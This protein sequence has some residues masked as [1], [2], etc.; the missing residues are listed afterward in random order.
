MNNSKVLRNITS[1]SK[2]LQFDCN[3]FNVTEFH[4]LKLQD[5]AIYKPYQFWIGGVI[6][7]FV[8]GFGLLMN[9]IGICVIST[10]LSKQNIFNHMIVILFIVDSTFLLLQFLF[11]L[12]EYWLDESIEILTI[13]TPKFIIPLENIT[14]TL[15]TFMTVAISHERC[16]AIKEP[17]KR[18]QLMISAKS[19]RIILTKY[20]VPLVLGA[21]TFNAP[22]FFEFEL[23][24]KNSR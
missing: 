5:F 13:I 24:W 22:R 15:S 20:V 8:S 16:I 11:M 9:V 19:R 3:Q 7:L 23:A 21:V 14:L 4:R 1:L 18:H 2:Y 10:R 17:I 12:N 6:A